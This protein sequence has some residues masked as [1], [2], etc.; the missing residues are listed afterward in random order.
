W[1]YY[2]PLADQPP[3]AARQWLLAQRWE[4]LANLILDDLSRAHPDIRDCVSR[5]DI[6]RI[7]HAMPRP[8]PGFLAARRARAAGRRQPR[9]FHAHSDVGGL[10]LFEE[11]QYRGVAAAD[12]AL[13]PLSGAQR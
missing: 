5:L 13:E 6:F 4:T 3:A 2:W 10:P 12:A 1:T 8:V 7:G 11:A 9:V